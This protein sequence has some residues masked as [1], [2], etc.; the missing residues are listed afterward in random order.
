MTK[1][2][3]IREET[4]RVLFSRVGIMIVTFEYRLNH[5]DVVRR[6]PVLI[7]FIGIFALMFY[8][9]LVTNDI[10]DAGKFAIIL[11]FIVKNSV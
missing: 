3:P 8:Y 1:T 10:G 4:G 5:S 6:T 7:L 2:D 9:R 11:K